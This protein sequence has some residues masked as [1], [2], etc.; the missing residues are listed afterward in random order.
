MK[1]FQ[2]DA[3]AD[4]PFRG[5]PAVGINEDPVTGSAHCYLAPYWANKL[6]KKELVGYQASKRGGII[7]C[8]PSGDRVFLKGKA[9]TIFKGELKI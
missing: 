3:F 1:I 2:V 7:H 5:N 9:V 4:K 8:R 6:Q